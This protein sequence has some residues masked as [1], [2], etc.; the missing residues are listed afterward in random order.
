MKCKSLIA[1]ALIAFCAGSVA[2]AKSLVV[3]FSHTGE[4]YGVGIITEGNTAV[5]AQMIAARTG[6]DTAGLDDRRIPPEKTAQ[7]LK[8][9]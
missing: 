5:I 7:R 1:A 9:A 4:Q 6:S 8:I 2:Q 3:Y